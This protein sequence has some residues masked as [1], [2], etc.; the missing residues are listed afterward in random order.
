MRF[1]GPLPLSHNKMV[2]LE[3]GG[4]FRAPVRWIWVE[5]QGVMDSLAQYIVSDYV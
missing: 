1:R 4:L 5:G 3:G 2:A